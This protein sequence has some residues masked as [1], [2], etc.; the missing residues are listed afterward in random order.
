MNYQILESL[1]KKLEKMGEND[2]FVQVDEVYKSVSKMSK[3]NRDKHFSLQ[4]RILYGSAAVSVANV[5]VTLCSSFYMISS[6][7]PVITGLSSVLSVMVT[8]WIAIKGMKKYSETWIRHQN[9]QFDMELEI[10][11]YVF[12]CEKYE[13]LTDLQATEIFKNNMIKIWKK[14]QEKFNSNM[15][16]FDKD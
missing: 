14:N 4:S 2:F 1:K 5:L 11:E 13:K 16:D 6:F 9:H 8:T 7:V 3:E 12:D 10:M 15:A